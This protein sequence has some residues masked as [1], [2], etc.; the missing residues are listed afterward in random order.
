MTVSALSLLIATTAM[1][2]PQPSA[3]PL[4]VI[5]QQQ[6]PEPVPTPGAGVIEPPADSPV[7]PADTT[8]APPPDTDEDIVVTGESRPPPGD[9]MEKVN[10]KSFEA[11]QAIDRAV[12]GPVANTYQEA[13]PSPIRSGLRNFL[14]NLGEPV[15]AL[16]YLLQFKPGKAAETVGRFAINTT[17]G[18]AGVMDV[19]K[20]KPFH[21]PYRANGFANTMGY[22]GIGPGPYFYLPLA[23]PTTLRDALG[24]GLDRLVLPLAVGAPFNN[25]A[26]VIPAYV[27]SSLDSRADYEAEVKVIR[28]QQNPYAVVRD[29]YLCRRAA[30]IEALHGR[31][32]PPCEL[33]EAKR[34]KRNAEEQPAAESPAE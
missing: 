26:Y 5:Y 25:P 13:V 33:T 19:A 17:V 15:N 31:E 22:Y 4:P 23:G 8:A 29:V 3:R 7:S 24:D 28:A 18:V 9:P 12:V 2:V 32:S 20:R 6:A 10:E 14:R 30:E 11:V 21:L 34:K 16:N 27:I 1:P